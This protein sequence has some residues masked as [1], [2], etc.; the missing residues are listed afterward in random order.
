[1]ERRAR[2]GERL[3]WL[4]HPR[5]A[6]HYRRN[7]LIDG[8]PWREWLVREWGGPAD[9]ALELGCGNGAA[10]SEMIS[11]G[12]SK[13]GVGY[14]LDTS[15]F[16]AAA[17]EQ[18]N[19][20]LRFIASDIDRI[21]LEENRYDLIYALQSFHHFDALD[22]IM[23]Q[24]NLALTPRGFFVLDEFVGP[25][26]FQWTDIQLSVTGQL[27]GIMPKH[28]RLYSHGME[29]LREGRSTPEEVMRVCPSE[30]IHS[31][32]IVSAF[33]R[34]FEVVHEKPLG[35]TLQHLLYSGIVQNF[36]DDDPEIDHL[37]DCISGIEATMI[38]SGAL[39]SDFVL[40]IGRKK[41][42]VQPPGLDGLRT[43]G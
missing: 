42:A 33:H 1:M 3:F 15:R 41:S 7:G 12:V 22:H 16:A 2:S 24:V 34:H 18:A 26:R 19:G 23:E 25:A 13:A 39:P 27:L 17:S 35:G 5:I 21:E 4:N 8:L 37:I 31:D 11:T 14:D 32:A 38:T 40:L 10:L 36:P 9:L 28:L 6:Y 20:C 43:A 30:A 29:K